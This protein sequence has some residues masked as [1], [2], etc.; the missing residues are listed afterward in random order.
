MRLRD[1]LA[2]GAALPARGC[3]SWTSSLSLTLIDPWAA[4]AAPA[5]PSYGMALEG[6]R[7]RCTGAEPSLSASIPQRQGR[8]AALSSALKPRGQRV[9]IRIVHMC[10]V[11]LA[12]QRH[13][14]L[15]WTF[16]SA[17]RRTVE[18]FVLW[19]GT[20]IL[21]AVSSPAHRRAPRECPLH[22]WSPLQCATARGSF[23]AASPP[24]A[25]GSAVWHGWRPLQFAE[26][27]RSCS[28]P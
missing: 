7:R 11:A 12:C 25:P 5:V 17:W 20:L 2:R 24:E 28:A 27:R 1:R 13:G 26:A 8:A 16:A 19:T 21:C 9:Y 23:R 14:G 10:G 6:K 22:G 15:C 4:A 3:A 18:S